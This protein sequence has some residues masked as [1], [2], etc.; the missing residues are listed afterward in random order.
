[1]QSSST[2]LNTGL[3][4]GRPRSGREALW[5]PDEGEHS[6]PPGRIRRVGDAEQGDGHFFN[7]NPIWYF[8]GPGFVHMR[9]APTWR[10]ALGLAGSRDM[11]RLARFFATLPWH[12]LVPDLDGR[13]VVGG[14][15]DD[16]AKAVAAHTADWRLAVVYIPA[17][18]SSRRELTLN[19][20]RF[21][22]GVAGR[23]FN[24]A[25]D[26]GEAPA[27]GSL[28]AG[29]MQK[30]LTPGDNGTGASDWV[31]VLESRQAGN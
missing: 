19:L 9:S 15:G 3:Q 6:A 16:N 31:L 30:L 18:G 20:S 29:R 22:G 8:D 24:P 23:W 11:S 14:A 27:V 2:R 17:D 4:T 25:A 10:E 28:S 5:Q 21:E 13:L 12:E 26:G 7:N 1:M